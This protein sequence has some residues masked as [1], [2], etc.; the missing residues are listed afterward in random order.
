M[1]I[2]ENDLRMVQNFEAFVDTENIIVAEQDRDLF[3]CAFRRENPEAVR[4]DMG[5][6]CC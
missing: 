1:Q 2:I 6:C 4:D 5:L 3:S